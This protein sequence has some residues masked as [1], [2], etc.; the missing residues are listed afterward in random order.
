MIIT[1][2]EKDN[3][4]LKEQLAELL[5]LTLPKRYSSAQ[6]E[7]HLLL[8]EERIAVGA[9]KDDELLGFVGALP[10]Y[11]QTE[12]ALH[13]LIIRQD[14]RATGIDGHLLTFLEK[15]VANQ[16][17]KTLYLGAAAEIG[18]EVDFYEEVFEKSQASG[19]KQSQL[20]EFYQKQGYH[21][22]NQLDQ[23]DVY[24]AKSLS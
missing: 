16:G 14:M 13:P 8:S 24:L 4:L 2:F 9:V 17:G 20:Y 1:L 7:V 19:N 15:E 18:A 6:E 11:D 23:A 12:W 22:V 3:N 10:Q 21:L 5:T